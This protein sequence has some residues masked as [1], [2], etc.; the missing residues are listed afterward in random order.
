MAVRQHLYELQ[1]QGWVSFREEARQLGRPA[2]L[3][4]L[5]EVANTHFPEGYAELTIS[6]MQAMTKT[7]GHDIQSIAPAYAHRAVCPDP[8]A[9]RS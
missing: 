2:K 9:Q 5:T 8:L 4:Q 7:F 3:W 1:K 6:L